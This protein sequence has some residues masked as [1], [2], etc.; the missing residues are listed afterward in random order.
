VL[1]SPCVMAQSRTGT[2][3]V[4]ICS[5]RALLSLFE[6]CDMEEGRER[7]AQC[8][9]MTSA[10]PHSTCTASGI[11]AQRWVVRTVPRSDSRVVSG[12]RRGRDS[13]LT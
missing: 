9:G 7:A 1:R 4:A 12:D 2:R 3:L 11:A 5:S 6:E 10:I 8:Q 13:P